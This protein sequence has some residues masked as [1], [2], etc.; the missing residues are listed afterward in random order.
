MF[1]GPKSGTVLLLFM[2]GGEY[3]HCGSIRRYDAEP[4]GTQADSAVFCR[5]DEH[6]F[7]FF[8]P[9]MDEVPGTE[10]SRRRDEGAHEASLKNT[11][12]RRRSG[13]P[14]VLEKV[15]S[16]E[17]GINFAAEEPDTEAS[18]GCAARRFIGLQK[19][20]HGLRH[21]APCG[22]SAPRHRRF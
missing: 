13:L 9:R 14:R 5:D 6:E 4:A 22:S 10:N 8:R 7:V 15:F 16:Y 11:F 18:A 1:F 19:L 21:P 2:A 3:P 17:K 12:S 20:L